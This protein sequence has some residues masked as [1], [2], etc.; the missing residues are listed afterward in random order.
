MTRGKNISNRDCELLKGCLA[1]QPDAWATFLDRFERS[2]R[3]AIRTV[4]GNNGRHASDDLV[5]EIQADLVVRLMDDGFA[6]LKKFHGKSSLN[7]WLEVVA[8]NLAIDHFRRCRLFVSPDEVGGVQGLA[9]IPDPREGPEELLLRREAE[10]ILADLLAQLSFEDRRFVQLCY[11]RQLPASDIARIMGTSVGAVYSR[12][13]RIQ[14]KLADL[15]RRRSRRQ[16]L[17]AKSASSREKS[18]VGGDRSQRA[19]A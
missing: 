6:R 9:D 1:L 16:A 2:V 11:E 8:R 19:A 13:C 10:E 4:V 18:W 5:C 7:H 17:R 14:K 3:F 15:E 12:K